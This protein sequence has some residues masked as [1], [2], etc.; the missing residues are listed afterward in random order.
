LAWDHGAGHFFV[1]VSF[2]LVHERKGKAR[3]LFPCYFRNRLLIS[4]YG[5]ET[6]ICLIQDNGQLRN[7]NNAQRHDPMLHPMIGIILAQP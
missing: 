3:N 7:F 5:P 6:E 1:I 2:P 4:V